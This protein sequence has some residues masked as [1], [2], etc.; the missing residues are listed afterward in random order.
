MLLSSRWQAVS[1]ADARFVREITERW[2]CIPL[3]GLI[4]RNF[5]IFSSSPTLPGAPL[6]ITSG[7]LMITNLVLHNS[8]KFTRS[9]SAL[10]FADAYIFIGEY[11]WISS[12]GCEAASPATTPAELTNTK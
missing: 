11:F 10:C 4:R 5:D 3:N 1:N 6:A 7:G 9:S 2:L 12:A 8:N